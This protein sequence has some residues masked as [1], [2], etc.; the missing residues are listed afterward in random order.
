MDVSYFFLIFALVKRYFG[1][2]LSF[3]AALIIFL[4]PAIPHHHHDGEA[5]IMHEH[6]CADNEDND[7]HTGHHD[8]GTLCI[9]NSDFYDRLAFAP[10]VPQPDASTTLLPEM[11]SLPSPASFILYYDVVPN[12]H[13][14]GH[15][16][17]GNSSIRLLRA[18][19]VQDFRS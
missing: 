2:F 17:D 14:D 7:C 10:E 9:E 13:P 5:C 11:I 4:L 19:P 6:C 18:P 8:D 15:C 16:R 1:I 3:L 12:S